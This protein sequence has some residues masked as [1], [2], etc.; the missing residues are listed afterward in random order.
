MGVGGGGV[1]LGGSRH[2]LVCKFKMIHCDSTHF[3]INFTAALPQLTGPELVGK[4][5]FRQ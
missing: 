1:G 4:L 2:S 5:K 3:P